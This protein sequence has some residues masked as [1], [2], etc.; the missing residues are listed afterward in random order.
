MKCPTVHFDW[1]RFH[2]RAQR[3]RAVHDARTPAEAEAVSL[4]AFRAWGVPPPNTFNN[5]MAAEAAGGHGDATRPL[6][7]DTP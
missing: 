2:E 6:E 3:L 7:D 1:E 4:E 5:T